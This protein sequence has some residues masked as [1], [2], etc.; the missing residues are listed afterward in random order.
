MGTYGVLPCVNENESL[1]KSVK[2]PQA[3]PRSKHVQTMVC[4]FAAL[5][6]RHLTARQ[7]PV[8]TLPQGTELPK[9]FCCTAWHSLGDGCK[10]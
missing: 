9:S 7:G 1:W 10:L 5:G 4:G 2:V 8:K 6:C 3:I